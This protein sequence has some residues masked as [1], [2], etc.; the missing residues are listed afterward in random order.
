[1]FTWI[2]GLPVW[3]DFLLITGV[4]VGLTVTAILLSRSAVQRAFGPEPGWNETVTMV[5][6]VG[7]VFYGLLLG[8]IAAATYESYDAAQGRVADEAAAIG[9][10][11]REVSAYPEP[12]RGILRADLVAYTRDVREVVWP[13][14]Q[15]GEEPMGGTALVTR[16]QGHLLEFRPA[17]TAQEIVHAATIDQFA[18]FDSDR[19]HRINATKGGIPDVLWCTILVGGVVNLVLLCLFCL[20]RH[21]HLVLGGLF[22]FFLGAMIF[23]IAALDYPFR[24]DLSVSSEPFDSVYANVMSP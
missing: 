20:G 21:A 11:Y 5:L 8:L 23:L 24:G 14:L 18:R 17:D 19:R 16:F 7:G 22:A 2:Y 10:L 6:T 12:A 4:A 3:L 13:A 9:T 1:M 15:R